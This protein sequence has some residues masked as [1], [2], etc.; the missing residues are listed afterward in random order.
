M[1]WTECM[2]RQYKQI[3]Q[4]AVWCTS[5]KPHAIRRLMNAPATLWAPMRSPS[6]VPCL[7]A[8]SAVLSPHKTTPVTLPEQQL[9][10]KREKKAKETEALHN[11][12]IAIHNTHW[13]IKRAIRGPNLGAIKSF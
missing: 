9:K 3:I 8:V 13:R 1:F 6:T 12:V 2:N 11:T 7:T 10:K 5:V 4:H